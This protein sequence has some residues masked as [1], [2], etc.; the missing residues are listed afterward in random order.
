[1]NKFDLNTVVSN[2]S[3]VLVMFLCM[4]CLASITIA[5]TY[6]WVTPYNTSDCRNL[7]ISADGLSQAYEIKAADG[8]YH[9][10]YASNIFTNRKADTQN[11]LLQSLGSSF[12]YKTN[13][14]STWLSFWG[15]GLFS[16]EFYN[17]KLGSAEV[18]QTNIQTGSNECFAVI[19][20][21]GAVVAYR[22]SADDVYIGSTLITPK[23]ASNLATNSAGTAG[24][25]IAFKG[26]DTNVYVY[27]DT[28][29]QQYSRATTGGAPA[30]KPAI[31]ANGSYLA[32]QTADNVVTLYSL[33]T[34]A[35]VRTFAGNAPVALS[36]DGALLT[37]R[38]ENGADTYL[39]KTDGTKVRTL[40]GTSPTELAVSTTTTG[41]RVGLISTAHLGTKTS[42][43]N[44]D[45]FTWDYT[46]PTMTLANTSYT[47]TAGS[48]IPDVAITLTN[49]YP[50]VDTINFDAINITAL[51]KSGSGNLDL[52]VSIT[53]TGATRTMSI[54]N[55]KLFGGEI[56]TVS[57]TDGIT[58]LTQDY[59][60]TVDKATPTI[61]G[62][63][64]S[65]AITYGAASITLSGT[66]SAPGGVY[67][68]NGETVAVTI[69]GNLQN[70]SIGDL[71]A[72][73]INYTTPTIPASG[74]AYTITYAYAGG[75]NLTAAT[76]DT[77]TALTVGVKGLTITASNLSKTY[78]DS[79]TFVG[80]EFDKN[81][82]INGDTI[83]SVTLSSDGAAAIAT[84]NTYAITPSAAVGIG[85]S[86][87]AITYVNGTL[88]VVK[89]ALTITASN[90]SKTY[91]DTFTF[92]GTEFTADGLIN[93]NT[94][95]GVTLESAGAAATATVKTYYITP[96]A[97]NGAGLGNY[98]ITY[99]NGS[100]TVG[101]KGLTITASN[102]SKTYGDAVTFAGTEFTKDGLINGD[103]VTGVTLISD[104]VAATATVTTYAI[105]PSAAVGIGLSNYNISYTNGTLTVG[106]KP[107]TITAK[108][109]SKT[110]GETVTFAGTEF[111]TDGLING[112]T[113]SGV[114]LSSAGAAA[115]ANVGDYDITPGGATGTG[116]SNYNIH[117]VIG[118]LT[119]GKAD[120]T[121]TAQA[122]SKTYDGNATAAA[123][124]EVTGLVNGNTVTDLAWSYNNKNAGTG[125]T[126]SI[127]G[128]TVNDGNGGNN[129]LVS[130]IPNTSGDIAQRPITV[131]AI[132]DSK[133][134]DDNNISSKVP[135]IT[136]GTLA[137]GDSATWTQTF[138]TKDV[139]TGKTLTPAGTVSDGNE[140]NNYAVTFIP[141]STGSITVGS[142]DVSHSTIT[143]T[144][145]TVDADG[146]SLITIT[147]TAKDAFNNVI[148][149]AAV[150]LAATG[151]D[152][153]LTQPTAVTDINGQASGTLASTVAEVKTVSA[154]IDSTLILST[155][156]ATF[157]Y[158]DL[159]ITHIR[160]D[161]NEWGT[162]ISNNYAGELLKVGLQGTG[163][164]AGDYVE[165]RQAGQPSIVGSFVTVDS[166]TLITCNFY[167]TRN[168]PGTWD[169]YVIKNNREAGLAGAVTLVGA[170]PVVVRSTA[171][172]GVA[173]QSVTSTILGYGF[174]SGAT[175]KAVYGET[176]I[177]ATAVTF[178][179]QNRLDITLNI[180]TDAPDGSYQLIVTN[181]DNQSSIGDV[182]IH[183]TAIVPPTISSISPVKV[184]NTQTAQSLTIN[185]TGFVG[186]PD[187]AIHS[188]GRIHAT[189]V[190]VSNGG[191]KITCTVNTTTLA[192]GKH[193]IVVT[194]ADTGSATLA[195]ALTVVAPQ[196][197]AVTLAADPA[198]P[199]VAGT[200]IKLTARA[201]YDAGLAIDYQF[202][203]RY[204]N[205]A[206]QVWAIQY[207]ND[208]STN[209][210]FNWA[211]TEALN[212]YVGVVAWNRGFTNQVT[213]AELNYPITVGTLTGV[214]MQMT[215][216]STNTVELK[217]I[218]TGSASN[219]EYYFYGYKK[220]N[221]SWNSF[222]IRT[223][224]G[225]PGSDTVLWTVPASAAY[226]LVV[227]ARIIGSTSAYQVASPIYDRTY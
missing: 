164:K 50:N 151:T 204:Y 167:L 86:N 82:L 173:G 7:A 208:F 158:Y 74:T 169:L 136:V 132:T 148:P 193:D 63:T 59:T 178:W 137:A 184:H 162:N 15:A 34:G 26:T 202:Y 200:T 96:S 19:K 16:N 29:I 186:T 46:P 216:K 118:K 138:D 134:Y 75:A 213:S 224:N 209:P 32:C 131:T 187:V 176:T 125:K 95:T 161:G 49:P 121:I 157:Y 28:A 52:P 69:N 100:L 47:T 58:T 24:T 84:V 218:K 111:T 99:A 127:T 38:S 120:L 225:I 196:L 53:T 2:T 219:V 207:L 71:G 113:V 10:Y 172:A 154:T 39:Y 80:T 54:T 51:K 194:N 180:P 31:S 110:Y 182:S 83:T 40:V 91:G 221:G 163:F 217:A 215:K 68:A 81:G 92:G 23:A 45:V 11:S 140:G 179:G 77:S 88:T 210:E 70:A 191:T 55:G 115:T 214:T 192:T 72:F 90:K 87:Y 122:N 78:G 183:F 93:G 37:C 66:V 168:N 36:A 27:S 174:D 42:G 198:S 160:Q 44:S 65:Q 146:D 76:S 129:Y 227:L 114:T 212:Y 128:Y 211:P 170:P 124:P 108:S 60:V 48:A 105:T 33:S 152:N 126:I 67:P 117:Y 85:L 9:V 135:T 165:L 119:V 197:N 57:A 143:A 12:F 181:P 159:S 94:V 166:P 102:C 101:V 61:T 5:S 106:A 156:D 190:V 223:Y 144:P 1:M 6:S 8:S 123:A 73:T 98:A 220:V 25:Y 130:T 43:S 139:G 203:A 206:T 141:V 17:F 89:K 222:T 107:L 188:D 155:A 145:G 112:N 133:V 195:Q 175:V 109:T 142:L 205:T 226:K 147:V 153:I 201:T 199:R 18:V 171:T 62:V 189:N 149:G 22:Q 103:T 35:V 177:N 4:L 79:T 20:S 64:A 185:G 30:D 13:P 21:V 150:M 3:K 41:L 116:L 97:A 104:G 56:I 14:S